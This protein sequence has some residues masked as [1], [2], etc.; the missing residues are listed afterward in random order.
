[1]GPRARAIAG[2]IACAAG[3][4]AWWV[5]GLRPF[6]ATCYAAVGV[7]AAAIG[8]GGLTVGARPGPDAAAPRRGTRVAPWGALALAAV[9]LEAVGL[10]LG[11][12]SSAVPTLSTVVDHALTTHAGRFVVFVAWL[13]LGVA[14]TA[15]ALVRRATP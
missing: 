4:G 6:T 12:R 2:V 15:R 10:A 13:A 1:M 11:G 8:I 5:T 7:I 9:V 3:G 14:P